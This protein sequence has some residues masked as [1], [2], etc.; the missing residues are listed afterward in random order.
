[1]KLKQ[2]IWIFLC[3]A[4]FFLVGW[5]WFRRIVGVKEGTSN[6]INQPDAKTTK[7]HSKNVNTI[8]QMLDDLD[9]I[10]MPIYNQVAKQNQM[11]RVIVDKEPKESYTSPDITLRMEDDDGGGD[12][13]VMM[14]TMHIVLPHGI[15]GDVGASGDEGNPGPEGPV[16]PRGEKG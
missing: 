7:D 8:D 3:M 1:M 15:E 16:G 2:I 12:G 14:P 10:L 11:I 4:L 9:D 13:D 5:V 6:I